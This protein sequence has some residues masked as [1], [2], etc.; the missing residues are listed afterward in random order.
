MEYSVGSEYI[1]RDDDEPI[2][3]TDI[4]SEHISEHPDYPSVPAGAM[5]QIV[6]E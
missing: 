6:E 3:P 2:D 4:E 1:Y 5:P